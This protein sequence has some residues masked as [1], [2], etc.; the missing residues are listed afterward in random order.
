VSDSADNDFQTFTRTALDGYTLATIRARVPIGEKFEVYGRVEN[1]F[2][3]A[4][5]TVSG[6]GTYGRTGHIGVRAKF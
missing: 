3:A 4:Y 2:D 1:L 6:Y 5:E